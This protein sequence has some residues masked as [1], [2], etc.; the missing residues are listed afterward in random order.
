VG[1]DESDAYFR[2]R[3]RGAQLGAW[4]SEQSEPVASR[5]ELERHFNEV[6]ARFADQAVPRPPWWGGFRIRPVELE[7]WQS[8]QNRLHD[9]LRY[10]L[11]NERWTIQRLNP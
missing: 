2:T 6:A 3:P 9:R 8:R 7:F 10:R 1:E 11:A 5:A 4:A